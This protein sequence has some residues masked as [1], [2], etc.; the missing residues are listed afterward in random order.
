MALC[1]PDMIPKH[2][3]GLNS[4]LVRTLINFS[5]KKLN[6]WIWWSPEVDFA[7]KL[8]LK[9]FKL[10]QIGGVS[11]IFILKFENSSMNNSAKSEIKWFYFFCIS[12]IF[13]ENFRL[14]LLVKNIDNLITFL[15][16]IQNLKIFTL[17][18]YLKTTSMVQLVALPTWNPK[19][20]G[21]I[22]G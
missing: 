17:S 4:E 13:Q 22:L 8:G 3:S 21:S 9:S 11:V 1:G 12:H 19:V 6:Q 15:K 20:P 7:P 16:I 2:Q 18:I 5:K 10:I 14:Q